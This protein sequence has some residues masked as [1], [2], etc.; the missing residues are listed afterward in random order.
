M[1][2]DFLS[3]RFFLPAADRIAVFEPPPERVRIATIAGSYA[4][5]ATMFAPAEVEQIQSQGKNIELTVTR[6]PPRNWSASCRKWMWSSA[7]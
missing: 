6:T 5:P 2:D 4:A 1:S 7:P 3:R